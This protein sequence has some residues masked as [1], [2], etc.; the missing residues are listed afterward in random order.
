V[1]LSGEVVPGCVNLVL[2]NAVASCATIIT[3]T[4]GNPY[5]FQASYSGDATYS[6]I[7]ASSSHAD[8]FSVQSAPTVTVSDNVG[9]TA[10]AGVPFII[11]ATVKNATAPVGGKITIYQSGVALANCT[12]IPVV[13][14]EVMCEVTLPT[15][16]VV[17]VSFQAS[18]TGDGVNTAVLMASS[19]ADQVTTTALPGQVTLSF[20]KN[21]AKLTPAAKKSLQLLANRLID[22]A[23]LKFYGYAHANATLARARVAAVRTWLQNTLA[24]HSS[25]SAVTVTTANTVRIVTLV[26]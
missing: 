11:A 20:A 3:S 21:S 13:S 14:N 24:I 25:F 26:D 5:V 16:S 12:A 17:P 2:T 10:V 22:G 15:A 19:V 1:Y 18:Y 4:D 7:A 6:A 9:N 8:T 23:I